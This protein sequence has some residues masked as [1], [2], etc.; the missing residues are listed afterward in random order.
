MAYST[1][2]R[3]MILEKHEAAFVALP[4]N[5][6]SAHALY[7]TGKNNQ[8][9]KWLKLVKAKSTWLY[10]SKMSKNTLTAISES[11]PYVSTALKE[12]LG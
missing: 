12:R 5:L 3:Q 2:Y 10:S 7:K 8:N 6:I 9:V 4:K 1:D 11:E